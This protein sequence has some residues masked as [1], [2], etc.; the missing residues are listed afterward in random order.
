[1]LMKQCDSF[2]QESALLRF[3]FHRQAIE[4]NLSS[5]RLCQE[6]HKVQQRA[7]AAS[8]RPSQEMKPS[9]IKREI[10][11]GHSEFIAVKHLNG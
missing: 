11:Y 10:I 9:S 6:S 7:L 4:E 2:A 8:I 5:I 1:M 3:P